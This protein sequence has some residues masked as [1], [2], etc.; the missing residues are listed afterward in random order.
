MDKYRQLLFECK[1]GVKSDAFGGMAQS[2][3]GELVV[4]WF[5]TGNEEKGIEGCGKQCY[6]VVAGLKPVLAFPKPIFTEEDN[7]FLKTCNCHLKEDD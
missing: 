3:E 1:C 7:E 2:E 6:A 4:M 5:C